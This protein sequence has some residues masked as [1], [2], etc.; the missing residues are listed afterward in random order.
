MGLTISKPAQEAIPIGH[1][2][3]PDLRLSAL[4]FGQTCCYLEL[5]W[6]DTVLH[7]MVDCACQ[8]SGPRHFWS[9]SL[10]SV[11]V[12]DGDRDYLASASVQT[13]VKTLPPRLAA[14]ALTRLFPSTSVS[15]TAMPY[16][17]QAIDAGKDLMLN[18]WSIC[19]RLSA[20]LTTVSS[21]W[22]TRQAQV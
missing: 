4:C 8:W 3:S 22:L 2:Y 10:L 15:N 11:W 21:A 16:S 6:L 12:L 1:N 14:S 19:P 18:V 5:T 9:R 13:V 20:I 7:E 17:W